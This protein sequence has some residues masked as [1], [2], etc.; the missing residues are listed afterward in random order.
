MRGRRTVADVDDSVA[1]AARSIGLQVGL[2]TAVI[3]VLAIVAAAFVF[4][5]QQLGEITSR[6][7]TAAL[8]ADDV[9][10]APP[11][12]WLVAVRDGTHEA[13]R[14]TPTTLVTAA[15]R[16]AQGPDGETTLH[17][18]RAIRPG[19]PIAVPRPTWRSTT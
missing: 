4:D 9:V 16:A 18:G 2:S 14:S 12:V 17:S 11:G 19:W 6:I 3:V 15:L 8:T 10:D 1:R 13:G 7:Q 5:R